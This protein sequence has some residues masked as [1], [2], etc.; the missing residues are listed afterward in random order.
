MPA[1]GPVD[2]AGAGA[3]GAPARRRHA[4]HCDRRQ[5][6]PG[7]VRG[8]VAGRRPRRADRRRGDSGRAGGGHARRRGSA[9]LLASRRRSD[10]AAARRAPQSRPGRG[11]RG[12]LDHLAAGRQTAHPAARGHRAARRRR[13]AAGNGTGLAPRTSLQQ[14]RDSRALSEPRRLREP[15]RGRRSGQPDLLRRRRVDADAGAGRLPRRA[16]AAANGVQPVAVAGVRPS[17][18]ADGSPADGGVRGDWHGRLSRR[19]QRA[20]HAAAA[21]GCLPRA[22]LRRHGPRGR[23][24]SPRRAPPH[25]A[26]PRSAARDRGDRGA[27]AAVA[28]QARRRQRRRGRARQRDL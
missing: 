5:A 3:G 27:R 9:L 23:R 14:A 11:G 1:R 12:R 8:R 21:A 2:Q 15:D 25:H 6:R 20:D 13:E 4:V 22:A 17:A 7:D 10:R 28:H 24:R 26:R 16:A 19:R 18:P